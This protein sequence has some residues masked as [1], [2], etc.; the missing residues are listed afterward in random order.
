MNQPTQVQEKAP[1]PQGL[2]PK[3]VQSWL[4][5]ALA[6]LMVA[7]MWLTGGK[8]PQ[9]PAKAA[10][11]AAPVQVPFEVNETKI[12]EMQN[13]IQELQRQQLVA[14]TALAQQTRSLGAAAHDSPQSQQGGAGG[15]GEQRAEDPIQA[16]RKRRAYVSLFASN[17][18]LSYRKPP[19]GAPV[20]G[21]ETPL[22]TPNP[23]PLA[24]DTAQIAQLLKD[25]QPNPISPVPGASSPAPARNDSAETTK[26]RKEEG[27]NPAAVSAGAANAAAG[28][29]YILFEGTILETVLINRLDGHL[30]GPVE[31]L[32]STDVYSNDR[33]HL[34]IPAG[35]KLL[36]ET[37]KVDTFGQTRLA[38][39]FHRLLMPDGYSVSLDQFKGLN[40]IGDTGLRDQVNN[41]YLRIFGVSLAIGAIGAVA[42]ARTGGSLTASG[43]DLM[44]QGFAQST[45]QSSAQILDK[46]LN[47]MPTVTIREGH[48]VKVYLAGD[49]ALPDYINHKMPSDL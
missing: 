22:A 18:A 8:K 26:D 38:V 30:A 44:R 48:R 13:R 16:E 20:Y 17:V 11:S 7:I 10:S 40:Q 49:L 6:F 23:L 32:L 25:M 1:K 46:F 37:K 35:S 28:K 19:A 31:C 29:N 41:H 14:Q 34:L 33:Q 24:R 21:A 42:E 45:A 12:A 3:N 36:G 39:V 9:T 47:V 2:L 15:Q 43:S 5:I 27:K 4:L